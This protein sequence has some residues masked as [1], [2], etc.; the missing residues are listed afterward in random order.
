MRLIVRPAAGPLRGEVRVPGDKSIAHRWLILAGTAQGSSEVRDLPASLDVRSTA[1]CLAG[2]LP[3]LR[4]DLLAFARSP[5]DDPEPTVGLALD[6]A[7][8]GSLQ[9]PESPLFCGNSGTTARL[10]SGLLAGQAFESVL[11]GD[12][13]LRRRPMERVAHP[14]RLMGADVRT[15]DGTP[16]VTV[17]GG[18]LNGIEYET[19]E[20]SAQVKS[21]VLLAGLQA[22]GTTTVIEPASTRDHT[23]RA[24]QALGAPLTVE[25][26]RVSVRRFQHSGF[27]GS[28]PGDASSAAFL[29]AA[30]ALVPGSEVVIHGMGLN[31]TRASWVR[32]L[33]RMGASIQGRMEGEELGEP[34]GSLLARAGDGLTG[35]V[36]SA[37][38]TAEAIDEVPV[39]AAVAAHAAGE[40]RFEGADELRVKESDRLNG[41]AEGI[42]GLGGEAAVEGDTLVVAGGGL[43]GGV[44][45]GH[46][47]HRLVMAFAVGALA[48]RGECVIDGGE[49]AG[50]SFPG[51]VPVLRELGAE[52]TED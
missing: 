21:A 25:P 41:M 46:E 22:D 12:H 2:L 48:A 43:S 39:L 47:D 23:E 26:R 20:P 15:D 38:E 10:L 37:D 18:F 14:L 29:A 28:I 1:S 40:S 6:G 7:G 42:R 19:P 33:E 8:F 52:V 17:L 51:F 44:A 24:L 32:H 35:I 4:M 16:P 27:A 3:E 36:L 49:W 31:S 11:D 5:E 45:L 13:S 50:I 34:V 30:A 9:P